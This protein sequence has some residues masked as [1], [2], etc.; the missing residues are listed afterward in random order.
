[1]ARHKNLSAVGIWGDQQPHILFWDP[2][3]ISETNRA[4]KLKFGSYLRALGL[5]VKLC[6]LGG[7]WGDQQLRIFMLGPLHIS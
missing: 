5:H 2:L 6:P 3:Y 7:V 4:R 1:M